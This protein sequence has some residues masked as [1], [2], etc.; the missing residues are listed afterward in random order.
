MQALYR[1][2]GHAVDIEIVN[3]F[4]VLAQVEG[5]VELLRCGAPRTDVLAGPVA[6]GAEGERCD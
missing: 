4:V 6:P 3:V 2:E 5:D 1:D